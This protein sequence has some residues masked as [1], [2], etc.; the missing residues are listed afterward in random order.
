MTD[1]ESINKLHAKIVSS[2]LIENITE[3]EMIAFCN[4]KEAIIKINK[5]KQELLD[6]ENEN[7]N[8][9]YCGDFDDFQ[10]FHDNVENILK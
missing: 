1:I 2:N 5:I 7:P 9:G 4:A 8:K 6:C 3:Q 10:T